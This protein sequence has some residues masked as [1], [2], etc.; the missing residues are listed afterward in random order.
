MNNWIDRIETLELIT[1]TVLIIQFTKQWRH[2]VD[3]DTFQAFSK[4]KIARVCLH[5]K[6]FQKKIKM[7]RL[8]WKTSQ[9]KG[10]IDTSKFGWCSNITMLNDFRG[11]CGSSGNNKSNCNKIKI[12]FLL[13][14]QS[15]YIYC[16]KLSICWKY[17]TIYVN[18][19]LRAIVF[20]FYVRC[21]YAINAMQR[22][23][24]SDSCL[25]HVIWNQIETHDNR[26]AFIISG[27]DQFISFY[28]LEGKSLVVFF[29]LCVLQ[30]RLFVLRHTWFSVP[31]KNVPISSV[32]WTKIKWQFLRKQCERNLTRYPLNSNRDGTFRFTLCC[33]IAAKYIFHGEI[34]QMRPIQAI[35]W[36]L[37]R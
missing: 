5:F 32:I 37:E 2:T 26:I 31:I 33:F 28:T 13:L 20:E 6:H 27:L 14:N 30:R 1:I 9:F 8:R 18:V 17:I 35:P 34:I 36:L 22:T 21:W 10:K 24:I 29:C 12:D 3:F 4:A 16:C 23:R 25:A 15:A 7:V 19:S 11:C